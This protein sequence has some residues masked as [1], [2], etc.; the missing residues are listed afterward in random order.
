MSGMTTLENVDFILMEVTLTT[1]L[2]ER[3][4]KIFEYESIAEGCEC[5]RA[6]PLKFLNTFERMFGYDSSLFF[7]PHYKHSCF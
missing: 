3:R 6:E 2:R 5:D 1:V 4:L 7:S